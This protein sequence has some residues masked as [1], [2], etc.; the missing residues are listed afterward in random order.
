VT[1]LLNLF[2]HRRIWNLPDGRD[3]QLA[4][5][6]PGVRFEM[7]ADRSVFR[8][9]LPA[10]D[11]LYSWHLP[12]PLFAIAKKLRWIHT[13]GAGI[14]HFL[15]PQMRASDIQISSG[16]GLSG[17]AMAEHL[18]A[19]M[20]AFSRRLH[21][22]MRLQ[23][24]QR[25]G[26]DMMW[27]SDP[28]PFRLEGK[29]VG[30]I[31]FGGIGSELAKRAKALGMRVVAI[32]RGATQAVTSPL[33]KPRYVDALGGPPQLDDL[34]EQS[35]FVVLAVPLTPETRGLIGAREL[36]KMKKTAYLLNVG[37]G[38]QINETS[39]VK[40]LRA[41]TIAGAA[42]DVFQNEPLP[43]RSIFWRLPNL[44]VSPHYAGTYPEHMHRATDRFEE[45]LARFVKG[46]T[47]RH[48]VDKKLGY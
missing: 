44:I 40:A 22:S 16:G 35:D 23:S 46:R 20:L 34:L 12:A 45:N 37:R 31:G 7:A 47:L 42:L 27:S 5:K 29:T 19:L 14:E 10:A 39:L 24:Q 21:D 3:E 26:Q 43:A 18:L 6:F 9:K 11:V 28:V 41:K 30:I 17:D 13:P 8:E 25:W 33:R 1:V 48:L 38:E 36:A 4:A 15:Y 32:R 2:G